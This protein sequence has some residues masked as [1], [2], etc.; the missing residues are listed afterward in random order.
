VC[1]KIK[2]LDMGMKHRDLAVCDPLFQR[3]L[4]LPPMTDDLLAFVGLHNQ[5]MFYSG[6]SLIPCRGMEEETSFSVICWM[7]FKIRSETR[8]SVF[9]FS[10]SSGHWAAATCLHLSVGLI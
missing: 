1:V 6:V 5:D 9:I 2:K 10:T 4:L 7:I 3:Y 8:L